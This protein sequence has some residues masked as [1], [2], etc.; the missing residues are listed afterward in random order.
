MALRWIQ[1]TFVRPG[2]LYTEGN[3]DYKLINI[4]LSFSPSTFRHFLKQALHRANDCR[5][6]YY[7]YSQQ[8]AECEVRS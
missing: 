2:S 7:L 3:A 1:I 5:K 4:S 8:G 6:A